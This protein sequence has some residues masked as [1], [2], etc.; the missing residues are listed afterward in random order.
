MDLDPNFACSPLLAAST[1]SFRVKIL[2]NDIPY[3]VAVVAIDK[4]GNAEHR[5]EIIY[6]TPIKTRASTT[7]IATAMKGRRTAIHPGPGLRRLLHAGARRRAATGT[8]LG[9]AG[10]VVAAAAVIA[11]RRRRR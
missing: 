10:A 9:I 4:S 6:G 1:R 3:G 8:A 2:Q 5:P 7:S 11:R